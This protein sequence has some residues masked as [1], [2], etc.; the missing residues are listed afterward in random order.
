MGLPLLL[1]LKSS[2]YSTMEPNPETGRGFP[3]QRIRGGWLY[4]P[5]DGLVVVHTQIRTGYSNGLVV[6]DA[7]IRTG[8]QNFLEP[9]RHLGGGD[10][11]TQPS[12]RFLQGKMNPFFN[13]GAGGQVYGFSAIVC[14]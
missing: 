9:S 7:Q 4:K 5:D 10:F 12:L 6:V 13:A 1:N 3:S 14:S 11:A 2:E 8:Y